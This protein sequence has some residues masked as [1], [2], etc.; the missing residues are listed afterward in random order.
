MRTNESIGLNFEGFSKSKMTYYSKSD[1]KTTPDVPVSLEIPS[2][3][4]E[5]N[6]NAYNG[7]AFE[8]RDEGIFI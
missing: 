8:K 3:D 6:R 7:C 4:L 5:T 1:K 2:E